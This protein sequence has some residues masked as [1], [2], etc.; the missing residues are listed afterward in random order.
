[1]NLPRKGDTFFKLVRR[2]SRRWDLAARR[3]PVIRRTWRRPPLW[4]SYATEHS[5][6]VLY[7][8]HREARPPQW[9]VDLGQ[10]LWGFT[11][12]DQ[13]ISYAK[14]Y[15]KKMRCAV[16]V[17]EV[18]EAASAAPRISQRIWGTPLI[19]IPNLT[20]DREIGLDRYAFAMAILPLAVHW[21]PE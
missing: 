13:C 8:L 19:F 1:M 3:Q 18:I 15:G 12:G 9:L 2:Y 5:A 11:D 20:V 7:D 14:T 17:C 21:E 4:Q 6:R 16:L 10:P